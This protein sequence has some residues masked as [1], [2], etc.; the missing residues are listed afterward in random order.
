MKTTFVERHV[1]IRKVK[2]GGTRLMLTIG[3]QTTIQHAGVCASA[4]SDNVPAKLSKTTLA[5]MARAEF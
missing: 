3:Q 4:V 2:T 1:V 5:N